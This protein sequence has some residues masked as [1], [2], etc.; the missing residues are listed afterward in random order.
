[1][2]VELRQMMSRTLRVVSVDTHRVCHAD[3][4]H[5]LRRLA[6]STLAPIQGVQLDAL[7]TE[8]ARQPVRNMV[9]PEQL[10]STSATR[11]RFTGD[12]IAC[13]PDTRVSSRGKCMR[14]S[15]LLHCGS[16][17]DPR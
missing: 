17:R 3:C 4:Q 14:A 11:A 2:A 15:G 16:T 5:I 13:R 10:V 9:L 8:I 6:A 12:V 7:P 1:M